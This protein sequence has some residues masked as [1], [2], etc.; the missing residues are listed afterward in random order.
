MFNIRASVLVA[1][2]IWG[3]VGLAYSIY[4]KKQG[5]PVYLIGGIVMIG[6]SYF[7][8]SALYMSLAS[9]ALIGLM[10]WLGKRM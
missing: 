9:L 2:L 4:G 5:E 10:Y 3:S 8:G 6:L 1:S 7:I